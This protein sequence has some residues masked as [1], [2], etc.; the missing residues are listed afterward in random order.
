VLRDSTLLATLRISTSALQR[1]S[2]ARPHGAPFDAV[3]SAAAGNTPGTAAAVAWKACTRNIMDGVKCVAR[4]F[5][6][7]RHCWPTCLLEQ[8]GL[9][10]ANTWEHRPVTDRFFLLPRASSLALLLTFHVVLTPVSVVSD[11]EII[12]RYQC[13]DAISSF[14]CQ[15]NIWTI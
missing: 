13:P 11:F 15:S 1:L 8:T 12:S 9:I 4:S 5:S 7:S 3:D 10:D 6:R 14:R 2:T